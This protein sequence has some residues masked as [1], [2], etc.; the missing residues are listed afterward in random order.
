MTDILGTKLGGRY[1]ITRLIG[2]GGMAE[3]YQVWDEDRSVSL[4]LKLLRDDLAEDRIFLNRFKRE[5]GN[6]S[7]LQHPNIVRFYGLE[8][9]G[10]YSYILMDYIEGTTLRKEIFKRE[11]RPFT[12]REALQIIQPVCA[13]LNYTHRKGLI[14]CDLKP[15]NI[16]IEKSGKVL[17]ADF[18]ISRITEGATTMT[19]AGAGTPAYMAPEQ[20]RGEEPTIQTDIYALGVVLYEMLTGGKRPFTGEAASITGSTGDMLRWEQI[21]LQPISPRAYNPS[22]S[23]DVEEIVMRCLQ[24][25]PGKRFANALDLLEALQLLL[26]NQSIEQIKPVTKAVKAQL[27]SHRVAEPIKRSEAPRLRW[28]HFAIGI[29]LLGGSF[30]FLLTMLLRP[31]VTPANQIQSTEINQ[32]LQQSVIISPTAFP[33][34]QKELKIAILAPLS[35]PVPTFGEMTR[36][37]AL[38]AVE[39]WN[40]LGG[41]LGMTII[42]IIE[43]SQCTP[44]PAVIAANKVINQDKAHYIIGEVC[45]RAS[46]PVSEIANAAKVIQISPTSTNASVTTDVNGITKP[47]IFRACFIDPFQGQVGAK[48]AIDTLN[49]KKAF[50]MFDQAND[51]VKGLA[52]SFEQS[53]TESGGIVVGKESYTAN[54]TDFSAILSIII[55]TK[56][57]VVYL[58][59]YYN[60]VNLV[61]QQAKAKGIKAPFLGGDG[62]DSSDLNSVAADGGYFTN[63]YSPDDPRQEVRDF[64]SSF[65]SKFGKTPDA[66]AALAYDST[67][68]MLEAVKAAGS[69]DTE[70]VKSALEGI[71]FHG[72]TGVLHFD[73]SHNP[74]KSATILKVTESRIVFYETVNPIDITQ[75]YLPGWKKLESQ[76]MEIWLPES[77]DGGNLDVN[78]NTTLENMKAL[79][80]DFNNLVSVIEQNPDI[81]AIYAFDT[82]IG[83]PDSLTNL[84]VL[85]E[86]VP[87][88]M[89]IENSID[90]AINIFPKN[91]VISDREV[92]KL[93]Q[94]TAGRLV[95]D[96]SASGK[97]NKNL[98]YIIKNEDL[99]WLIMYGTG[100]AEFDQR[101]PEFEKSALTFQ[102][103]N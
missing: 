48:F 102:V 3:V 37:G 82:N 69:D 34:P 68:L 24:K 92:V 11:N 50:I 79:G 18:G 66:L 35:G 52:Q 17:L 46:I 91:F 62:W 27:E 63:H 101:L 1:Q 72:V 47:Y 57:D 38:L 15:A 86:K 32:N 75:S 95:V 84:T 90:A 97:K 5:A 78:L 80:S 77:Y 74:I 103:K 67:N 85:F 100:L 61:T 31:S 59:D 94:Y 6:L 9:D 56:P 21:N 2:R 87:S 42:P 33:L 64:R 40:N 22:I 53:F 49:A 54:D 55:E 39:E 96:Y 89:T 28:W 81:F 51:Y 10:D 99:V 36:D 20:F 19:M 41:V 44:D 13:A 88:M 29:S 71:I 76:G 45:S 12:V 8:M 58:P 65:E 23:P 60:I 16:M 93:N 30:V 43:D 7:K 25:D 14:H 4:A 70:K 83:L 98:I 73:N 26:N